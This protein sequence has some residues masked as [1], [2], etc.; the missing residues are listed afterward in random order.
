V[1]RTGERSRRAEEPALPVA[2]PAAAAP[3]AAGSLAQRLIGTPG[4]SNS[5]VAG[6]LA[7]QHHGPSYAHHGPELDERRHALMPQARLGEAELKLNAELAQSVGWIG[8]AVTKIYALVED[9][10]KADREGKSFF[11][12]NTMEMTQKLSQI[13]EALNKLQIGIRATHAKVKDANASL[14]RF[15]EMDKATQALGAVVNAL[16][17][18]KSGAETSK[19]LDAFQAK[20]GA[21][22][23]EAW[24][25]SVVDTFDNFGKLIGAL[26]LP[27]G[28]GWIIDYFQG[29]LGAPKAYVGFF[30]SVMKVR[31][32]EIDRTVG[33]LESYHQFLREGEKIV[34]AGPSCGMVG[35]AWFFD[36]FLQGWI[37]QQQKNKGVGATDLYVYAPR[38][39]AIIL[40]DKLQADSS[41]TED[42][43][44]K[45]GAWL[46]SRGK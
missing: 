40:M 14:E 15:E 35:E 24:A 13:A 25:D 12:E 11:G 21:D 9:A 39:L 4:M 22:T 26:N 5:A 27:P 33:R 20:P 32:G 18:L 6:M 37:V 1:D 30:K 36:Q 31:Y 41:V 44:K 8:D 19:K 7:R 46:A 38:E 45:W 29:L 17:T 10:R 42:N 16:A 34:W 28:L 2:V 23:A 3:A 43:K